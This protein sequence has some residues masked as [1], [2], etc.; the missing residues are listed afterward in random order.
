MASP[1][2]GQNPGQRDPLRQKLKNMDHTDLGSSGFWIGQAMMILATVVGVYLA[3][4]AGLEQALAF[5]RIQTL[6]DNYY[7]RQSLHDELSDNADALAA[8]ATETLQ[9]NPPLHIIKAQRPDLERFV[10]ETMRFSQTTLETPST[11][12]TSAR[13]FYADADSLLDKV[14]ERHFGAKH[15]AGELLTLV[16]D[17]RDNVLP[18]LE[19]SYQGL[20]R[21][22]AEEGIDVHGL[23]DTQG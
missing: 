7:L 13:R 6:Q 10:W 18:A 9:N 17:L 3:A 20:A 4:Y 12:L 16:A 15:G 5:D 1:P 21:Q 14:T 22:L 8:F 23:K 11:F 2:S 19:Q